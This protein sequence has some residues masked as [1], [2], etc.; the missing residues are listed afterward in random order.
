MRRSTPRLTSAVSLLLSW[1]S[2]MLGTPGCRAA[3]TVSLNV[4]GQVLFGQGI[5]ISWTGGS[6]SSYKVGVQEKEGFTGDGASVLLTSM[7][8]NHLGS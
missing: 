5:S 8:Q 7:N 2:L 6:A 4:S 3:L 1:T